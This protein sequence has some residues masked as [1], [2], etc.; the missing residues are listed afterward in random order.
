[1][2]TFILITIT[3]IIIIMKLLIEMVFIAIIVTMQ[4]FYHHCIYYMQHAVCK[5]EIMYS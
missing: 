5:S 3:L 1:M 4:N 2:N